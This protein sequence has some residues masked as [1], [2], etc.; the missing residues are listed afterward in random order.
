[1]KRKRDPKPTEAELAILSVLWE[2]GESTVRDVHAVL[3]TDKSTGYTTTLK[4]MQIM[5]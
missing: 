2:H 5:A 1:M 3:S 4:L